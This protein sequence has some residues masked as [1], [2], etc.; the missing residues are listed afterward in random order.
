MNDSILYINESKV[1]KLLNWDDTCKAVETALRMQFL[2]KAIQPPRLVTSTPDGLTLYMMPGYL[3][4]GIAGVLA[5]K[6]VTATDNTLQPRPLPNLMANISIFNDTTGELNAIIAGTEITKWRTAAASVIAT[7]QF[8]PPTYRVLAI[9]GA[10]AQAEIHALAFKKYFNFQ[11][12]RIWN[13]N[14][15]RAHMLSAQLNMI[16]QENL[17]IVS[18]SL[19]YCLEEADVIITATSS[20]EPL[21]YLDW[22]KPGVHINAVGVYEGQ[23]KEIGL[24]VYKVA[25]LYVDSEENAA[26][27]MKDI[28]AEGVDIKGELGGIIEGVV[29]RP[30]KPRVTIFQSLGMASEDCAMA[31]LV[32]NRYQMSLEV[33]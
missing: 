22:I 21:I 8:L 30:N 31:G 24:P 1:K 23:V 33:D 27:E 15:L 3:H 28:L 2:K 17:C 5:C 32:Y 4:D 9:L 19:Q 20:F 18:G 11:Q 6:M 7:K 25:D 13:H 16:F 26:V 10:G 14:I 12:I 29:P